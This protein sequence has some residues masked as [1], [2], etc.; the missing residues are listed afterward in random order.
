MVVHWQKKKRQGVK[1][2]TKSQIFN[3]V[4]AVATGIVLVVIVVTKFLVGAWLVVILI[5]MLFMMFKAINRH[6]ARVAEQ[7]RVPQDGKASVLVRDL[8]VNSERDRKIVV[9][10]S[11]I[12]KASLAS[13]DFAGSLGDD[14]T[15]LFISD[16][17]EAIERLSQQWKSFEFNIPLVIL[18]NPFRSIL[19]PLLNY[20]D[21]L[22]K[23]EPDD[24]LMVVLPEFVARHW[25]EQV[26]HNQ[27][28][29][30]IKSALLYRPGVVVVDVPYHMERRKSGLIRG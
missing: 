15:A 13:L 27:T 25:W 2:V 12:N 8:P 16:E 20:I 22:E 11:A 10:I 26:L 28:A 24:I 17:A 4:G 7:L 21:S 18:E 30:R 1:G 14:V 19:P 9:P 23:D 6:Y 3:A 29:L 5:P